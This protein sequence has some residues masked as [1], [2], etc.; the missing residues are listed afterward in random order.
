MLDPLACG[1]IGHVV[2]DYLLQNDW[3]ATEKKKRTSVCLLHCALYGLATFLCLLPTAA[4]AGPVA[5]IVA[6]LHFPIDRTGFVARYMRWFGQREFSKPP[7]APWSVILVDNSF[8]LAI[9]WAVLV[10]FG[11]A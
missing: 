11:S 9:L 4:P 6:A 1:I 3:I 5:A 2:G 7:L 8:H 10:S